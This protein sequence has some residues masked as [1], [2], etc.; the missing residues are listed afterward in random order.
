MFA[1]YIFNLQF[2]SIDATVRIVISENSY[3]TGFVK[4]SFP[5]LTKK[6]ELSDFLKVNEEFISNQ[7]ENR[8]MTIHNSLEIEVKLTREFLPDARKKDHYQKTGERQQKNP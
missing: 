6:S 4:S 7:Q 5:G 8:K 1:V 3:G 2:L